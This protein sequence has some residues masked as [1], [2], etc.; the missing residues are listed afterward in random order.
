MFR[1]K[2]AQ[3]T[4]PD[5]VFLLRPCF[6]EQHT[7][8][9]K[10]VDRTRSWGWLVVSIGFHQATQ[11]SKSKIRSSLTC[12][13]QKKHIKLLFLWAVFFVLAVSCLI[14]WSF[15]HLSFLLRFIFGCSAQP[16]FYPVIFGY[17]EWLG[18]ESGSEWAE[19]GYSTSYSKYL[20]TP[21]VL[22]SSRYLSCS[23]PGHL[24]RKHEEDDPVQ[25]SPNGGWFRPVTGYERFTRS[26]LSHQIYVYFVSSIISC[27]FCHRKGEVSPYLYDVWS[28]TQWVTT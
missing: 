5:V 26:R 11:Q 18:V 20:L 9:R 17:R 6:E 10:I 24:L 27:N 7:L 16:V 12:S 8:T 15:I 2:D 4:F 13:C 19:C 25:I 28:S 21:C 22:C 23:R 3:N 1:N 14:M